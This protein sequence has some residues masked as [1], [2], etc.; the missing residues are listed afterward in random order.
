MFSVKSTQFAVT[1]FSDNMGDYN[2]KTVEYVKNFFED[3]K[4]EV[5]NAE[6]INDTDVEIIFTEEGVEKTLIVN[7]YT[8]EGNIFDVV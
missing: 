1:F 4:Y 8:G 2:D 3:K 6:F 7:L 5:K